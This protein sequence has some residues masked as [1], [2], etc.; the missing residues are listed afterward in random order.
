MDEDADLYSDLVTQHGEG[1]A[2]LQ[3]RVTELEQKLRDKERAEKTQAEEIARLKSQVG[4][5]GEEKTTLVRNIS[6]IYRT[7]VEEIGRHEAQ[8]KDL[9]AKL[10]RES[11]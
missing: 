4:K 3:A 7:A 2:L 8:I 6:C 9:R 11:K 1:E 10:N 5:L